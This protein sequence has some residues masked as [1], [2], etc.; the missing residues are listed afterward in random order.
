MTRYA[1]SENER[2]AIA[3]VIAYKAEQLRVP[4]DTIEESVCRSFWVQ[5]LRELMKWDFDTVIRHL[6]GLKGCSDAQ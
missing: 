1:L 6:L 5:S 4:R 2:N 3:T